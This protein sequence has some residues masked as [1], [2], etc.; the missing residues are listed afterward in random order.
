MLNI[1]NFIITDLPSRQPLLNEL[2]PEIKEIL[3]DCLIELK[4][5][6]IGKNIGNGKMVIKESI[7][8]F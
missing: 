7:F 4:R 2:K 1:E 6:N 8:N 3:G 5:L